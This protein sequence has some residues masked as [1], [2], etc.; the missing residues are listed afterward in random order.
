M[1]A[2]VN[3]I[4]VSV[5]VP[6]FNVERFLPRCLDSLLSQTLVD[7]EVICVNDASTDGSFA[8][9]KKYAKADRRVK[10]IDKPLNEGLMMARRTAYMQ[11]VGEYMFFC[12]SDDY[13]PC[14]ALELLYNGAKKSSADIEVGEICLRN[15]EGKLVPKT[16]Y[17][18]IGDDWH[19]YLMAILNW[20]TCS[21]CGS[22][23]RKSLFDN[24]T[25][26][27]FLNCNYSE[28]RI[29][30]SQILLEKKPSVSTIPNATYYY[31]L[32]EASLT[33]VKLSDEM[34]NEQLSALF[35]SYDY[36]NRKIQDDSIAFFNRRFIVRYLSLYIER[37]Y[38]VKLIRNHNVEAEKMMQKGNVFK[39]LGFRL[40]FH[41]WMCVNEP[42][43]RYIAHSCRLIIRKLQGKD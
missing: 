10:V 12:D 20:T 39:T 5:L 13:I 37:G 41:T 33:H 27:T 17:L 14:Q 31:C 8:I 19:T 43:Y 32:N 9:L 25:Y 38:D 11:A 18:V 2:C 6:V 28:D 42:F 7:I 29:L 36:V 21:L 40:G 1:D 35:W 30:L 22:I 34:L 15:K 24:N 26:I 16:R 4:K 23:Y 3:D